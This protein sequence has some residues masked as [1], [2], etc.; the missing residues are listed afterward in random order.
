M[1][2]SNPHPRFYQIGFSLVEIMVGLVIGLLATLVVLQVFSV[3]EGQKRTTTGT[4]DAQTNGNVALYSIKRDLGMAG[5]GLLPIINTPLDCGTVGFNIDTA[6]TGIAD[7]SHFAPV[8]IIDG[9]TGP[10]ASDIITIRYSTSDT[11]GAISQIGAISG[12]IVAVGDNLACHKGDLALVVHSSKGSCDLTTVADLT[13]G[14]YQNITLASPAN[15]ANGENVACLGQ[16]KEIEYRINSNY[17]PTSSNTSNSQAYLQRTETI[18]PPGPPVGGQPPV[19]SVAD[20]VN[21]QAQYGISVTADSNKIVQ[22][23]N[24]KNAAS[25]NPAVDGPKVIDPA[26]GTA[27]DFGSGLTILN[28]NLIKAARIAVVARN[29]LLEKTQVS[30]PCGN[31]GAT[32][33]PLNIALTMD[34]PSGLCA[35]AGSS[36]GTI[37]TGYAPSID[38]SNDPNWQNYRY[39]V[40]ETI[41]PM[42]NIIWSGTSLP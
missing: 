29:G 26:T 30:Y 35:W 24:A 17:D 13:S 22:W 20:I 14:N 4:A 8:T 21:I 42:R 16:W 1:N 19:P 5:Y 33:F 25:W 15:T 7:V 12:V 38:L 28:R 23:V 40:F 37:I 6:A 11:G 31:N 3:F 32:T 2:P 34:A 27:T 41:I 10:G 9:G 39:R 36:A 18:F